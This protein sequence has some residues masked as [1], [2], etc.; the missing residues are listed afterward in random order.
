[1]KEEFKLQG[2][3]KVVTFEE[4]ADGKNGIVDGPFGSNLKT[5]DYINDKINGVPV[6]TTKNL[7]GDYSD[8]K[9]RFISKDKF[10]TL[11]RSQVNPGDILV[12]KIG[13]IG[14]TG[15][16]PKNARIAI[17]PAN[18]LKFTVSKKVNFD[19][20][21]YYINSNGLQNRIKNISTATAQ[22]AFNVTKFRKLRIPLP[23]LPEQLSIVSKIEELFSELDNGIAQLKTAQQQ[24][25]VY[26]Q[27]LLNLLVTGKNLKTID[28]VIEKLDQ[29]WSPK[30]LNE[31][32]KDEKEWAVIKTS[33]V[34]HG[35]FIEIENKILP[36]DLKPRVQHELEVG[37]I[38]ITRAGPRV[39]VGVCCMIR[40]TRQ[41]LINCDKVYR[42]KVN[43]KIISPEYF[44]L[45][46]NTPYYQREI[47]KMKSGIS[48]SGL[49]LTQVK[50]L[51][52]EIPIPTLKEQ[53][54][55]VSELE[56]KLTVCDKIEETISQ[57]L[58]Q[59]E[60]LRQSILKK[61]FEGELVNYEL[62]KIN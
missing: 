44:E 45:I 33:A 60:M 2:N 28:S 47:E 7:G 34:Q 37:D 53:Q 30:C 50:F 1:M 59:A 20:V 48:D 55:I 5:S 24:L 17:I 61:A 32:S 22:P 13:S 21:F 8:D 46:L 15:I 10:E 40:K 51:K 36:P 25:K 9:V 58:Q 35:H 11:K 57:S 4:I 12:A 56:S 6:L 43:T 3:W 16:Y 18:L 31:N 38:L 52:I 54:L 42:I 23:P 27:S 29:G 14:K 26:R 19:Y 49:N 39:R 41:R 62:E